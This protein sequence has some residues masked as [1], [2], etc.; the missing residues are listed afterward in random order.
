[1]AQYPLLGALQCILDAVGHKHAVTNASTHHVQR[2]NHSPSILLQTISPTTS[3]THSLPLSLALDTLNTPDSVAVH[4]HH[5]TQQAQ[6]T[7][8][9]PPTHIRPEKH[10]KNRRAA[11]QAKKRARQHHIFVLLRIPPLPTNKV[12][13]HNGQ[14]HNKS[15]IHRRA[16]H[17]P[18]VVSQTQTCA[19]SVFGAMSHERGMPSIS[20]YSSS[21]TARLTSLGVG[22]PAETA[23]SRL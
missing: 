23:K 6:A 4:T 11:K 8:H 20:R 2:P 19:S 13:T 9:T 17:S 14:P 21:T 10:T 18:S 7:P 3:S 1:M 5:T 15:L 22:Q 12:T 16:G